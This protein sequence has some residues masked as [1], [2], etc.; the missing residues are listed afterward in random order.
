M[1]DAADLSM[2]SILPGTSCSLCLE[3]ED[4][5]SAKNFLRPVQTDEAS[6]AESMAERVRLPF[7]PST[8]TT[9][10]NHLTQKPYIFFVQMFVLGYPTVLIVFSASPTMGTKEYVLIHVN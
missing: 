4:I 7:Q 8:T 5:R 1:V 10:V 3:E 6:R 9:M 2:L